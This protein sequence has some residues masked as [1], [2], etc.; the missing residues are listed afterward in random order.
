[1]GNVPITEF[2][3]ERKE[4]AIYRAWYVD[5]LVKGFKDWPEVTTLQEML[6]KIKAL[7]AD[8][9]FLGTREIL[10]G[11]KRG[12][13]HYKSY[14]EVISI[15]EKI[16]CGLIHLNVIPVTKGERE[17]IFQFV[18]INGKNREEW[19]EVD[20]ACSLYGFTAVALYDTLGP[21]ALKH[22]FEQ[23]EL[24]T[25]FCSFDQVVQMLSCKGKNYYPSLKCIISFDRV[26]KEIENQA[27]KLGVKLIHWN[28]LIKLGE[29]HPQPLPKVTPSTIYAL[30]YTSGTTSLPKG[31][32][33]SQGNM[34]AAIGGYLSQK[35][36]YLQEMGPGDCYF[37]YLPLAHI[38]ERMFYQMVA[39]RG[40]AIG[41]ASGGLDVMESDLNELKPSFLI[42]V[43]RVYNRFFDKIKNSIN[44]IS[45]PKKQ[46]IIK[47]AIDEKIH[48]LRN[49]GVY[50]HPK[51]DELIFNNFKQ[52]IG[53]RVKCCFTSGAPISPEVAEFLK[54]AFCCPVLEGMGMTE[55]CAMGFWQLP[56][57]PNSGRIGPAVPCIEFK[58]VDVPEMNYT[59]LDKGPT[60]EPQPRGEMCIRGPSAF[61][62]YYKNPKATAE[63]IDSE[64]WVHTGDVGQL[65]LDGTLRIIDRKKH[66]FKLSQ[67][68]YVAPEKIENI[69]LTSNYVS[70]AFV[71]G[72][73]TKDYLVGVI[74]PD[75]E[76]IEVLA[77]SLGIKGTYEELCQN[78]QIKERILHEI[79]KV[80]KQ[81]KLHGFELVK[82]IHLEPVSFL[83]QN[84]CT[85]SM[86]LKRTP[87]TIHYKPILENLYKCQ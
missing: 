9:P 28:E 68:E 34:L 57:D 19:I 74:V 76:N 24:T 67:G 15:S 35:N 7:Y 59:C 80:G 3:P 20:F 55:T 25:V 69:Y 41:F 70:E 48:R 81:N 26:T 47:E 1:M 79:N 83:T 23:T 51:Y 56:T 49:D 54:V 75:R 10:H 6:L 5:E 2:R 60:G 82:K 44:R 45:D 86:K 58:L 18:G 50:V 16:A 71:H 29:A 14:H 61:S 52:L 66:I 84:L 21:D 13:Y 22:I 77:E 37:T 63:M 31:A 64:G 53:G 46:K 32:I 43:P 36:Q 72:D 17:E 4:T 40:V 62:S 39:C 38:Y 73:S 27:L 11:N 12:S 30:N 8:K 87:A 33:L 78:Q 42:G 85:A 65:N